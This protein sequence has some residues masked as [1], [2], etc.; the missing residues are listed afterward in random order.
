MRPAL[1]MV[2]TKGLVALF[3]AA[4]AMLKHGD[5]AFAGWQT[6]GDG[7]VTAFIEGK[8][9]AVRSAVE[10]GAEAASRIGEVVAVQMIAEPHETLPSFARSKRPNTY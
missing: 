6:I 9:A 10:A 5:V 3:E 4:D 8:P 7:L 2:E 1:G